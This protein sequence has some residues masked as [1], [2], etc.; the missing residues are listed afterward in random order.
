[1]RARGFLILGCNLN[2]QLY[3]DE[4]FNY[5][6]D[7]CMKNTTYMQVYKYTYMHIVEMVGPFPFSPEENILNR[8]VRNAAE[9][10]I[11]IERRFT[12]HRR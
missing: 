8:N 4:Y 3:V 6:N 2:V 7:L 10:R 1:M 9:V 11:E 5:P 12:T